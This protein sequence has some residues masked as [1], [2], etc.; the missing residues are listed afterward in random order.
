M[1]SLVINYFLF[2]FA[3]GIASGIG[4]TLAYLTFKGKD[5]TKGR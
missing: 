2:G 1:D 3:V 4:L 5:P